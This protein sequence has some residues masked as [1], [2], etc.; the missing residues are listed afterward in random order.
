MTAVR[1]RQARHDAPPRVL[2]HSMPRQP[3]SANPLVVVTVIAT[4]AL[5]LFAT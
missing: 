4:L 3:L 1:A 2:V 5:H